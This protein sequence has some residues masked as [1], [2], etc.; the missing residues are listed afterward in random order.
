MEDVFDAEAIA[1]LEAEIYPNEAQVEDYLRA[2]RDGRPFIA[3][4]GEITFTTQLVADSPVLR[5]FVTGPV[6]RISRSHALDPGISRSD[7]GPL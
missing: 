5:E 7:V 6:S 3:R 4:A 2:R 1:R